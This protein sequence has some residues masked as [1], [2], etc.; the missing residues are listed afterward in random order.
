M[1]AHSYFIPGGAS[2]RGGGGGGQAPA[3]HVARCQT[4]SLVDIRL[5]PIGSHQG[6][7]GLVGD[8][9]GSVSYSYTNTGPSSLASG[10]VGGR[11]AISAISAKSAKVRSGPKTSNLLRNGSRIDGLARNQDQMNR[12]ACPDPSGPLLSPKTPKKN[13][14]KENGPRRPR[15]TSAAARTPIGAGRGLRSPFLI[16]PEAG[17]ASPQ[18]F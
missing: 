16:F 4:R 6:S 3:F 14:S 12:I 13:F 2:Q 8:P 18:C 11:R 7:L 17:L 9:Y 5:G 15:R 10:L 1:A